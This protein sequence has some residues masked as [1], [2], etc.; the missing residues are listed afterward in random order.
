VVSL[1]EGAYGL[2]QM[3][4]GVAQ[5]ADGHHDDSRDAGDEDRVLGAGCAPLGTESH[6][7]MLEPRARIRQYCDR[8]IQLLCQSVPHSGYTSRGVCFC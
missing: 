5:S 8:E 4:R 2:P 1:E 7:Q 3:Q 6:V